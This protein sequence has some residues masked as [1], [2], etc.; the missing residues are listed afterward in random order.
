MNFSASASLSP[1]GRIERVS[2]RDRC[3]F[4][5]IVFDLVMHLALDWR[6]RGRRVYPGFVVYC[7]FEGQ[8]G[9]EARCAAFRKEFL[10]GKHEPVPF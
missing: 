7:A 5:L 9:F 8:F 4:A 1:F 6:Y 2:Q 10:A 3:D